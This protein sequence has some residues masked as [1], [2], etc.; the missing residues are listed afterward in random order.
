MSHQAWSSE[1]SH[2]GVRA[3]VKVWPDSKL[4]SVGMRFRILRGPWENSGNE[5]RDYYVSSQAL[6]RRLAE[7]EAGY[8]DAKQKT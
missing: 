1:T 7:I 3:L 4:K 6:R 2:A 8:A 5:A